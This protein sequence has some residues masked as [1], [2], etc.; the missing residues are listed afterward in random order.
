MSW[1]L[2]FGICVARHVCICPAG[3]PEDHQVQIPVCPLLP[4]RQ[5]A[6]TGRALVLADNPTADMFTD[7]QRRLQRS[8]KKCKMEGCE[9]GEG[10]TFEPAA[11]R[12]AAIIRSS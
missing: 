5:A 10:S 8:C 1:P 9:A 12:M 3:P 6:R 2:E 7:V 4:R 11:T